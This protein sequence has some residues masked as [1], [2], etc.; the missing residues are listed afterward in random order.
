MARTKARKGSS[1]TAIQKAEFERRLRQ[2]YYDPAFGP[3]AN[4]IEKFVA[5]AWE[6]YRDS[7]KSPLTRRAGAGFADPDYELS[8]EW[9]AARDAI[10]SA[11]RQHKAVA[12]RPRILLI[13]GSPR[14]DQTCPGEV[15][16]TWRL[17]KIAEK[18]FEEAR[19]IDVEVLDLSRITAERS[20]HIHPCKA[21]VSTAMPLCHWPCSCYPNHSNDQI[22][23]W[24]QAPT[25]L[26]SM[27]DRLVC[28]DGGNPDPTST[29]GKDPDRAKAIEHRGWDFPRHLE[30]RL[31]SLVVHGD[32][33]GTETLRRSLADWLGDMGLIGAGHQAAID[34]YIGYYE[35]YAD[36]HVALD[37]DRAV[38]EE[39]RNAAWTLLE[40]VKLKCRGKLAAADSELKEPRP[41]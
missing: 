4:D 35:N 7:R 17:L 26:K 5:V 16:K 23:P 6:A 2:R 14:S 33:A 21:C 13:N 20:L 10:R 1:S 27:I 31:F 15:S 18:V 34:R 36:N 3:L 38:Q 11:E 37:A 30:G 40:A 39:T 22:N 8:V 24:Y 9:L 28:A 12:A 25:V 41:K 32:S 19:G 29:G